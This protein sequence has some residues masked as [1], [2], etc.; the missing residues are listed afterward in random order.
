MSLGTS[1]V[2]EPA[3]SLIRV[4]ASNGARTV[5]I[6]LEET[7]ISALADISIRGRTGELLP[8]ILSGT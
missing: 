2:V 8:Q 1:G 4:A 6:N 7:P 3:A 5:E